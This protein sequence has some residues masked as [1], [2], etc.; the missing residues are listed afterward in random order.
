MGLR[1]NVGKTDSLVCRSCQAARNQS[2]AAYRRNMTGEG[3]TYPERQK[4]RFESME[5]GKDVAAGLLASHRMMHHGQ[6]KE[7][8]WSW[9]ASSTGGDPQMY[10]LAFP[11]KGG[12]RSCPVGGF[13]V[14]AGTGTLMWMHFCSRHVRDIVIIL[15]EG[16]LPHQ[17][18]S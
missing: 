6:A 15:G 18:C 7:E 10:W 13:P 9:E 4:E 12:P 14:R 1:T 16:N 2:E 3:P 5:Y 8:R 11:T 17:R